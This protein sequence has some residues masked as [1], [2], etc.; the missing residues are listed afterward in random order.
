MAIYEG[1]SRSQRLWIVATAAIVVIA[2]LLAA[3]VLASQIGE[4]VRYTKEDEELVSA[5][6]DG[7]VDPLHQVILRA[8]ALDTLANIKVVINK[9]AITLVSFAGAFALMAIGFALFMI[10]ADGAF[11]LSANAESNARLVFSG[12]A[13]GLLCFLLAAFMIVAGIFHR[14][15]L[16]LGEL[17]LTGEPPRRSANVLAKCANQVGDECVPDALV[18]ELQNAGKQKKGSK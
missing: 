11:Q 1:L 8:H 16:Q 10:G 9:Q 4:N 2:S 5:L 3:W 17:R 13:P 7:I 15:D 12:T 6:T 14:Y 18:R